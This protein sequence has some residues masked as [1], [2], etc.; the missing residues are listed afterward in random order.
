MSIDPSEEVPQFL[1]TLLTPAT[2]MARCET[3]HL[4]GT[5]GAVSLPTEVD[6][7]LDRRRQVITVN[8]PYQALKISVSKGRSQLEFCG[9]TWKLSASERQKLL[10]LITLFRSRARSQGTFDAAAAIPAPLSEAAPAD[11]STPTESSPEN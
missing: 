10:K 9:S 5:E 11:S 3:L 2:D 8:V 1:F 4:S 6:Q 7:S